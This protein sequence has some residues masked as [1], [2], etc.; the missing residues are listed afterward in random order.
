MN[1]ETD[2]QPS[3]DEMR[4]TEAMI[5]KWIYGCVLVLG[6]VVMV[7]AFIGTIVEAAVYIYLL[8][9]IPLV[10]LILFLLYRSSQNRS[11]D[12]EARTVSERTVS[13]RTASELYDELEA[14]VNERAKLSLELFEKDELWPELRDD[15]NAN[16]TVIP[17]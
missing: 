12:Q 17:N 11:A 5:Y 4:P 10:L 7:A 9:P 16:K 13:E 14:E 15:H 6:C 1:S 8:W 2:L 3:K